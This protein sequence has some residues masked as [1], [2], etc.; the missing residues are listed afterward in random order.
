MRPSAPD[1][2]VELDGP[3]HRIQ[4]CSLVVHRIPCDGGDE[5]ISRPRHRLDVHGWSCVVAKC[6]PER[7]DMDGEDPLLDEGFR[8]DACQQL[9]FRDEAARLPHQHDEDI[10]GFRRHVDDAGAAKQL[11]FADVECEVAEMK[12]LVARHQISANLS[13]TFGT[14]PPANRYGELRSKGAGHAI[15]D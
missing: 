9:V 5:S 6:F 15:D 1:E 2:L 7:G 14:L 13:K 11:A 10:K 8:P 4:P 12:D 3:G